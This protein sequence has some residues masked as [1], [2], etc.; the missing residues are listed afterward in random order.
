MPVPNE[1]FAERYKGYSSD[2]S[3]PPEVETSRWFAKNN[4]QF[5]DACILA[6]VQPTVRQ[7]RKFLRHEGSAYKNREVSQDNSEFVTSVVG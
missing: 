1:K 7:A 3:P 2:Y 5:K 6:D 4:K